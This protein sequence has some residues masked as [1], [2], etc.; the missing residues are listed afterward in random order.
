MVT[1]LYDWVKVQICTWPSWCHCHSLSLALVNP[2]WLYCQNGSAFLVLAYPGC[3]GKRPLNECTSVVCSTAKQVAMLWACAVKSRPW[4][5]DRNS[6]S[7]LCMTLCVLQITLIDWLIEEMYGVWSGVCQSKRY[8]R[9]NLDRDC[10]KTVRHVNWTGRM[11][12]IAIH[13]G[14]R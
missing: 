3:P 14:S 12:L 5:D 2:G 6:D 11:P 8:T 4:L 7:S 1:W 13:G 10:A 9:Q